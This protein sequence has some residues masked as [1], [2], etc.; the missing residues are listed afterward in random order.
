[1]NC[2]ILDTN[3]IIRLITADDKIK[4]E[5]AALLFEK[6]KEGRIT[7]F[8]HDVIFAE[9]V[10][11]LVSKKLYNLQ[12]NK[13]Q[14]LLLPIVNLTNIKFNNKKSVKRALDLF[15]KYDLDFED[16]LIAAYA[17]KSKSEIFSFDR[18]F[19]KISSIIAKEPK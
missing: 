18:D 7:A 4:Q 19:K 10:F 15:V 12:K 14:A 17:E 8:I 5:K 16:A 3:I 9:I 11:V 6:I 13:I 1:M 2:V